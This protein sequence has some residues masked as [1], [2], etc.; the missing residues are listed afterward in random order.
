VED[1]FLK[2]ARIVLEVSCLAKPGES[3]LILTDGD[4]KRLACARA[5][6]AAAVELGAIPVIMDV[7][8][9]ARLVAAKPRRVAGVAK[10]IKAAVESAD[11]VIRAGG[12][13]FTILVGDPDIHDKFLTAQQRR[14]HLQTRNM[15]SW[16]ITPE[17][18]AAIRRRTMWLLE[19]LRSVKEVRVTSPAGTDFSFGLGPGAKWLPILGIVPLYGEVAITPQQGSESG[20]YVVDGPTQRGVRPLAETGRAPLRIKVKGGTIEDMSGD[21]EQI[22]RL[23]AYIAGGNPPF[24]VID[25]VGIVTTAIEAN[26]AYWGDGTHRHDTLHIALG[27][28][29]KRDTLVHGQLHMD[30]EVRQPTVRLDGQVIV[31]N[32]VF[33]DRVMKS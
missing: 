32:G 20:V 25:E 2:N 23:K 15:E 18:V 33:L 14:V 11:I 21:A 24:A 1:R 22:G 28:N 13:D 19:R 10:P 4:E 5:L 6:E 26:D 8:A 16:E 17:E 7:S 27:N 31:E 29:L 30:G 9:Y 12:P 3:V